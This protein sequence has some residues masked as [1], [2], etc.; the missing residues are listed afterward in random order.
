MAKPIT[1]SQLNS[2]MKRILE[3]DPLLKDISIVG[4]ISNLKFHQSGDIYFSLKDE[5]S[6]IN[7]YISKGNA[8]NLNIILSDG[9][10]IVLQGYIYLYE[11]FG[12]Y[13]IN[14][15]YVTLSGEGNLNLAF[16]RLKNKLEQE[17]LFDEKHKRDLP[18][19]PKKVAVIT[20]QTGAA[21]KDIINTIKNKNSFVD[22]ILYPASVQG[23]N[24]KMELIEA[25]ENINKNEK[26]IDVAIIGRGG[27]A[28]EDLHVFNEEDL[29]RAIF[30]C[31]VPIVSAVGHEIDFS[32]SDF[33]AD[34]RA[35]TPTAA[36][37]MVVPST[38]DIIIKMEEMKKELIFSLNAN[39]QNQ[40]YKLERYHPN[41]LSKAIY[42]KLQH[43]QEKIIYKK[44]Q[45]ISNL[46]TLLKEKKHH[47]DLKKME[48]E[49]FDIKKILEKGYS[50]ATNEEG[51]IFKNI[52]SLKENQRINIIFSDGEVSATVNS[53]KKDKITYEKYR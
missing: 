13:S 43:Y 33:V 3:I 25:I 6:K 38:Y 30:H 45:I 52:K 20:S 10:E 29:A 26:E 31:K 42:Y 37:E 9:I 1:V 5:K 28:K 15:K 39:L 14:V 44:N 35:K 41:I 19:F 17:G 8:E 12:M 46:E 32:I 51:K 49:A 36:G 11:P 40:I 18:I 21:V 24:A 16:E 47:I 48:I 50:I 53:I 34:K 27:G 4:E 23:K 7:C 2:Y 22:I